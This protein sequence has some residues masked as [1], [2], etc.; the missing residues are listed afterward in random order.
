MKTQTIMES[1]NIVIDD[2]SDFAEYSKEDEIQSL[3]ENTDS[4]KNVATQPDVATQHEGT[5]GSDN[6]IS[7]PKSDV[8]TSS[9]QTSNEPTVDIRDPVQKEPSSRVKKNHPTDLIIGDL[10]DGK[11]TRRR[12]INLVQFL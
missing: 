4:D 11:V 1:T 7:I 6:H 9:E 5:I 12:N 8:T 3:I 2:F 10:E